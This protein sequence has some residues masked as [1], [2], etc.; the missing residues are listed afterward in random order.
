MRKIVGEGPRRRGVASPTGAVT[1]TTR[2]RLGTA[3]LD[4]AINCSATF[5]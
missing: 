4:C 5:R 2:R 1:M 3:R